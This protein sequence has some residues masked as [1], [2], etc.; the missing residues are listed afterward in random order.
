MQFKSSLHDWD[1]S[2]RR[3][4]MQKI[5]G[6]REVRTQHVRVCRSSWPNGPC[7]VVFIYISKWIR[8]ASSI[9][10]KWGNFSWINA[11]HS[12]VLRWRQKHIFPNYSRRHYDACKRITCQEWESLTGGFNRKEWELPRVGGS[13]VQDLDFWAKSKRN[14]AHQS[15]PPPRPT[16]KKLY[17]LGGV[18]TWAIWINR[19]GQM[20][21][22]Y[23]RCELQR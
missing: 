6:K 3:G 18:G 15:S 4:I 1:R 17:Q 22:I 12:G 8:S 7:W 2:S 21:S 11:V 14:E 10:I 23:L 9:H 5:E 13:L 16:D 19:I 20:G